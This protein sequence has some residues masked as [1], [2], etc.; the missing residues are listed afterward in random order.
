MAANDAMYMFGHYKA[1]LIQMYEL[2]YA[3]SDATK[4]ISFESIYRI[5]KG[6]G[7]AFMNF[8]TNFL[9]LRIQP[10]SVEIKVENETNADSSFYFENIITCCN[11]VYIFLTGTVKSNIDGIGQQYA[12]MQKIQYFWDGLSE[13]EVL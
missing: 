11:Q 2:N 4:L 12:F 7:L 3:R 5:E 6:G 8:G 13:S 9:F 1:K 10:N